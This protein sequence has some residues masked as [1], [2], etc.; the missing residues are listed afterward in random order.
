MKSLQEYI[1]L[2]KQIYP[3][4]PED[5]IVAKATDKSDQIS[6]MKEGDNVVLLEYFGGL[7]TE[8]ETLYIEELLN[9]GNLELNKFDKSGIPYA[10]IQDFTLQMSLYLQDPIIQNLVLS[11]S[12]GAIWEA[13]KLSSV[14]IWNTVK[15]RH[16][17]SKEKQ[18]KH[19]INFGFKYSTKNGD[20]IDIN[21]NGDLSPEQ[22]NK[23][24]DVLPTLISESNNVNHPMNSGFYYFDK[25]QN[26][27]IGIDVIEEIKKRH[28]KKKK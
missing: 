4:L 11:V 23:A 2:F 14:F 10:S 13:L 5:K 20:K 27:W 3:E 7:I 28:Y 15:E 22:L 25:D 19:T 6:K 8:S 24:L 12:G 18:E 17:N 26:K 16:W 21:L 9:N 1:D